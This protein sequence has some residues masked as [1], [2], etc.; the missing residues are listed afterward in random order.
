MTASPVLA[1]FAVAIGIAAAGYFVGHGISKHNQTS[2]ISVKGL[3]ERE[4]PATIA[5]WTIGYSATGDQL[6][7]I[8][9][10]L[11]ESAIAV[12]DFLKSNG[13]DAADAALQPP[14]IR[15]H[16]MDTRD[17]DQQAPAA[18]FS[19][20]Q[21]I[22][23]RTTKVDGIKPA[24][25]LLSTVMEK[26]VVLAGSG[27]PTFIFDDLNSI[28]PAMIEEATK[29]A[30]IAGEQFTRD[31]QTKLGRLRNATQGGF[32]IEDRDAATPERKIVRVIV[33]VDYEIE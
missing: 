5:I 10:R 23:V 21:S 12:Q 11:R 20:S 1:S 8:N 9:V 15:D 33:Q 3:A 28:K 29:N 25:S 14:M 26:G 18:R 31:S 19:A 22:L 2:E 13:F 7:D 17:K 24:I 32:T 16:S 4:V 6:A 27:E 30:R